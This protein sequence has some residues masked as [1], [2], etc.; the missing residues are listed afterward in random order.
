[1]LHPTAADLLSVPCACV[2]VCLC[3]CRV[4][5]AKAA[6]TARE[7]SSSP[8]ATSSRACSR[9]A[10]SLG[11]W[12]MRLQKTA[13]GRPVRALLVFPTQPPLAAS[14]CCC[15]CFLCSGLVNLHTPYWVH[16]FLRCCAYCSHVLAHGGWSPPHAARP[17]SPNTHCTRTQLASHFSFSMKFS[18]HHPLPAAPTADGGVVSVHV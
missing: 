4:S 5:G 8:T 2:F 14:R 7:P 17:R 9:T 15:C 16:V 11:L 3:V 1:M 10:A 18:A 13:R 12:S 6:G